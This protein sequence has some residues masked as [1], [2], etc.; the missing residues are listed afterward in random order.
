MPAAL[1]SLLCHLARV[2][3]SDG[4]QELLF[5]VLFK[6]LAISR[7]WW[8]FSRRPTLASALAEAGVG[9]LYVVDIF[10]FLVSSA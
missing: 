2:L 7:D 4:V 1:F 10:C 3:W 5:D 9:L 8:L 6:F